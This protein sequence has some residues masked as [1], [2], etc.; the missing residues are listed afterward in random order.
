M[1]I[2]RALSAALMVPLIV[3]A[4]FG[5]V[6]AATISLSAGQSALPNIGKIVQSSPSSTGTFRVDASTGSVSVISGTLTRVSSGSVAVPSYTLTC[7]NGNGGGNACG[8]GLA[9]VTVTVHNPV[10]STA[11]TV[12]GF[13]A[14]VSP[15]IGASSCGAISGQNTTAL[16]FTCTV[17]NG[18][19]GNGKA[20]T[21]ATISLGMDISILSVANTGQQNPGYTVTTSP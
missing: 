16:S 17:V 21:V 1:Q 15:G 13:N 20:E 11:A 10:A 8:T 6:T 7:T 4:T 18:N 3:G 14:I 19:P 5:H 12:A 9:S 2:T